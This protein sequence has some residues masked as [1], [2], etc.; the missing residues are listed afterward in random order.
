MKLMPPDGK[1]R[2]SFPQRKP[3]Q[4]QKEIANV[5]LLRRTIATCLDSLK[6]TGYGKEFKP[7]V[8]YLEQ[9]LTDTE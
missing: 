9:A 1:E 6:A 2:D 4:L 3:T 8:K 7:V 5:E